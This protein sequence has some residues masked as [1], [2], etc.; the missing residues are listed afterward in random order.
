MAGPSKSTQKV[1]QDPASPQ[2]AD[3]VVQGRAHGS[4]LSSPPDSPIQ[5]GGGKGLMQHPL[6]DD[7]CLYGHMREPRSG[8]DSEE[9][10]EATSSERTEASGKRKRTSSEDDTGEHEG[11]EAELEEVEPPPKKKT[12]KGG[13]SK[14]ANKP[15]LPKKEPEPVEPREGH[16]DD[17]FFL[18]FTRFIPKADVH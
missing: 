9:T 15:P 16:P 2:A 14:E 4:D 3:E 1:S 6:R 10:S 18:E 8:S 13:S 12:V 7:Q 11:E 5:H 17:R